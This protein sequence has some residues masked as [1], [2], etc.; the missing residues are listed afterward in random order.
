M[1]VHQL[2]ALLPAVPAP[3]QQFFKSHIMVQSAIQRYSV[4]M[5]SHLVD[6]TLALAA[7][8]TPGPPAVAT[9]AAS[10]DAAYG[11]WA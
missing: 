3:R 10:V 7:T 4:E 8:P 11:A 1:S 5:M 2:Q 6:A 9:A